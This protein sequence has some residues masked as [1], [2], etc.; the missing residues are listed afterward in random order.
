MLQYFIFFILGVLSLRLL[1]FMLA[2]TPNYY[3]FK[4]AEY[5]VFKILGELHVQKL[6]VLKLMEICYH[7]IGKDAEYKS[8]ESQVN[9]RYDDL[10]NRYIKNLKSTLPYKTNYNS[11]D[12]AVKL[13]LEETR[14]GR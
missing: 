1:Q 9:K 6:T 2:I 4:H 13:L 12:E 14:N 3:I 8:V 5:T 10:I 7:E 11:L